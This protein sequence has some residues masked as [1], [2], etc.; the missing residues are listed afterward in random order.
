MLSHKRE[1]FRRSNI[2][3]HKATKE[4]VG[5]W[6][7]LNLVIISFCNLL[8]Y[9]DDNQTKAKHGKAARKNAAGYNDRND[10]KAFWKRHVTIF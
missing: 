4:Y 9:C 7:Y 8:L 10:G 1:I 6:N 2:F 3:S 5:F